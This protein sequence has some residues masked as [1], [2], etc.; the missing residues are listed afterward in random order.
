MLWNLREL[1]WLLE[2]SLPCSRARGTTCRQPYATK[3]YGSHCKARCFSLTRK[4]THT[5]VCLVVMQE[6]LILAC[7][8]LHIRMTVEKMVSA[9]NRGLEELSYSMLWLISYAFLL[10][11]PS[12]VRH[13]CVIPCLCLS[14]SRPLCVVLLGDP[15]AQVSA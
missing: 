10:R 11:L 5:E 1:P 8:M 4:K 15:H 14:T 9:V 2:G 13:L 3:S 6:H 7:L 12:E